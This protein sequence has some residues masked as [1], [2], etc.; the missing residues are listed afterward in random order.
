MWY[1]GSC[2]EDENRRRTI[3][4]SMA[5]AEPNVSTLACH[6]AFTPKL[7]LTLVI[8]FVDARTHNHHVV[9]YG[10]TAFATDP[11]AIPRFDL[12]ICQYHSF[13]H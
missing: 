1:L 5:R 4:A 7:T 3:G 2:G 10:E 11:I 13:V 8:P 9:Y 12:T 6:A